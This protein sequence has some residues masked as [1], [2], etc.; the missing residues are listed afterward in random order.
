MQIGSV[1]KLKGRMP[2]AGKYGIITRI[3]EV[4]A[5][6]T[7]SGCPHWTQY[8]VWVAGYRRKAFPFV[9]KNLEVISV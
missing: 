8:W 1:V 9:E 6:W 2:A 7:A 5:G 4:K 3:S